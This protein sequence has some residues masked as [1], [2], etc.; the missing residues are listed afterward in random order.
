MPT[1][2]DIDIVTLR[3]RAKLVSGDTS[4][5]ADIAVAMKMGMSLIERYCDRKFT[6]DSDTEEFTHHS[7]RSVSLHRYPLESITSITC[8]GTTSKVYHEDKLNGYVHFDGR[9]QAHRMTVKYIGGYAVIPEDIQMALLAVFD[10]VWEVNYAGGSV[11]TGGIK[12]IRAG[13]LSVTYDNASSGGIDK[14]GA[15]GGLLPPTASLILDL[16]MRHKM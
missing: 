5:D 10:S 4:R 11:S 6:R 2:H 13:D 16:Y 12:T 7:G 9:I 1:I 8:D 14:S 15:F 3:A